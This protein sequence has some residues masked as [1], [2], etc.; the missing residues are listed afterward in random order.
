MTGKTEA[1]LLREELA[2]L[3]AVIG[4]KDAALAEKDAEVAGL[5]DEVA[6][7][8]DEVAEQNAIISALR[9][10]A[11]GPSAGGA[12]RDG[13]APQP[14]GASPPPKKMA[15]EDAARKGTGGGRGPR[16]ARGRRAQAG[17]G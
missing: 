7:L 8:K 12:Y 15:G 9:D 13:P 5:K 17:G 1:G 2:R 6:G 16:R 4:D 11:A 3:V 10:G 14:S